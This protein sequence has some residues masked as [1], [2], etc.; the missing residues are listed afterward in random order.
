MSCETSSAWPG[1]IDVVTF[2][3][4]S[5]A[6]YM[7]PDFMLIAWLMAYRQCIPT[8]SGQVMSLI[9]LSWGAGWY[10]AVLRMNRV[11]SLRPHM[12]RDT[13]DN[14]ALKSLALGGLLQ[15]PVAALLFA[16]IPAHAV[17]SSVSLVALSI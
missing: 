15:L 5:M 1:S 12:S 3:L 6:L 13:A 11:C 7:M 9:I 10:V 2:T 17:R 16:L 4:F 8:D 14:E